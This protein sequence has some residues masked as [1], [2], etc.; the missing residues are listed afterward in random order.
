MGLGLRQSGIDLHLHAVNSLLGFFAFTVPHRLDLAQG[1][2]LDRLS[3]LVR[4]L[5]CHQSRLLCLQAA[6]V[7]LCHHLLRFAARCGFSLERVTQGIL[8]QRH[9]LT[10]ERALLRRFTSHQIDLQMQAP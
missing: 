4:I 5:H 8:E 3:P 10:P 6:L 2:Q 1:V 7:S 9:V